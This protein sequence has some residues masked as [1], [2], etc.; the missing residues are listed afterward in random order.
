MIAWR[1]AAGPPEAVKA[2]AARDR[3]SRL[4]ALTGLWW[5]GS[6]ASK[7]SWLRAS[8]FAPITTRVEIGAAA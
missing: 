8:E 5:P 6:L 1:A 2:R 7:R 3:R 4:A